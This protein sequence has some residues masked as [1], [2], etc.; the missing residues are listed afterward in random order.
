ML[1]KVSKFVFLLV[2]LLS[3][4]LSKADDN[5]QDIMYRTIV[6]FYPSSHVVNNKALEK[7]KREIERHNISTTNTNKASITMQLVSDI[8]A[9]DIEYLSYYG[10]GIIKKQAEDL[11]GTKL[12]LIIDSTYSMDMQTDGLKL[13]DQIAYDIA[14]SYDGALWDTET[15][16]LFTPAAWENK[17]LSAWENDTPIVEKHIVIH[18][19]K[20]NEY[21]RAIT[22][23]MA[24]FGMPDIVVNDFS[25]SLNRSVESLIVLVSQSIVEGS[26]L[27]EDS[28]IEISIDS[29]AETNYKKTLKS[30]LIDN[31]R[32]DVDV[33]IGDAKWEEGDPDNYLIEILFDNVTGESVQIRQ[34]VLLSSIFGWED[35]VSY[36]KHNQLIEDASM[37]AKSKLK[38]L[39]SDFNLGLEPG[40]FIQVK[41]P[42]TTPDDGVEWMWVEVMEWNGGRIKGLLKN[43]PKYIPELKG[44]SVVTVK[45]SEIFDYFRIYPDGSSEGN[46]TGELILKYR[47]L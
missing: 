22:L 42:F 43:Q 27:S 16:E 26:R 23:G 31:A 39:K 28:S 14:K 35:K 20:N 12:A 46:E 40:E 17:R 8:Q 4:G 15:R 37:R 11:Q 19:Y 29:L 38:G 45:E 1:S 7:Y 30:S 33:L 5:F 13:S 24:K 18:A 2:L 9:P 3:N 41:A 47:S 25:W 44:G 36:V 21:V 34:E 10:R 6:Y 32:S